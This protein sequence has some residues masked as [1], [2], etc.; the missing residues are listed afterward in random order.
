VPLTRVS[1]RRATRRYF[2]CPHPDCRRQVMVFYLAGGR[3]YC[4]RCHGSA[5]ESQCEDAHRL[6]LR[7]AD[8]ARA[9]LGYP[10][11]RPFSLAP[12][13][14]PKGMWR[15]KFSQLQYLV[16]VTDE[17]AS[18]AWVMRTRALADRLDNRMSRTRRKTCANRGCAIRNKADKQ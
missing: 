6:I 11:W 14:R 2:Q 3:F 4:R 10:A 18:A 8:K 12:I 13:A 15:S 9:Q 16:Y 17:I 5:Y 1:G 7:H